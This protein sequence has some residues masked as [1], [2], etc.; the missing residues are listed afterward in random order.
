M[1]L[2]VVQLCPVFPFH[3]HQTVNLHSY[4]SLSHNPIYNL[5]HQ[6][7]TLARLPTHTSTQT[8]TTVIQFT[9]HIQSHLAQQHHY[10]SQSTNQPTKPIN[11]H[12]FH[13]RSCCLPRLHPRC[14]PGQ[15]DQAILCRQERA[16]HRP[17]LR[18][19]P[20]LSPTHCQQG[21]GWRLRQDRQARRWQL[22]RFRRCRSRHPG[23]ALLRPARF[24]RPPIEGVHRH[25]REGGF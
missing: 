10:Y 4:P 11:Q 23:M 13:R 3:H 16:Q 5:H 8:H 14:R 15:A 17:I 20:L 1:K 24:P 21:T 22:R 18:A 19:S 2:F 12:V 7:Y 9:H 6:G 25:L